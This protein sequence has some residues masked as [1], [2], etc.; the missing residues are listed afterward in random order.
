MYDLAL[1]V[2]VS[3]QVTAVAYLYQPK[4]KALAF[5]FPIPFTFGTLAL[6]QP[7]DA[8]NVLGLMLV[9]AFLHAVRIL[10]QRFEV[11]IVIAIAVSAFAYGVIGLALA[12]IV[13][14]SDLAFYLACSCAIAVATMLVR[15]PRHAD[16][17]GHRTS[18]PIW[19]KLPIILAV[20]IVLIVIKHQLRGF[21]ASFPLVGVLAAYEARHSLRT[22]CR[23]L[24]IMFFCMI[25]L[26]IV[27]RLLEPRIGLSASLAAG[28]IPCMTILAVYSRS[29]WKGKNDEAG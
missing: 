2:L 14:G 20:V 12:K 19:V 22:L 8:T 23:Q 16:E 26:M 1:V 28:W 25:P 4:W 3:V 5:S 29:L 10:Y 13:P 9:L 15:L 17:P 21:M 18:L 24:T 6:G 11:P 7:V 27:S